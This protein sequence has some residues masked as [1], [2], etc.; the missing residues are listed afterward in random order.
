MKRIK[1]FFIAFLLT[2]CAAMQRE[3]RFFEAD[4]IALQRTIILY[5][6]TGDTLKLWNV[7]TTIEDSGGCWHF[8]GP[9]NK[10][11]NACGTLLSIED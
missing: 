5:S 11:I 3:C 2:G 1:F 10:L 7:R 8:I 6:A 4:T 9:N